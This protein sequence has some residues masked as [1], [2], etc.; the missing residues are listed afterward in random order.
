MD[1]EPVVDG[2]VGL[3]VGLHR[4]V[5]VGVAGPHMG[6]HRREGRP[7]GRVLD[8]LNRCGKAG[9]LGDLEKLANVMLLNGAGRR[10]GGS[11]GARELGRRCSPTRGRG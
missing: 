4:D 11:E 5:V 8:D 2:E 6:L 3:R 10:D 1:L 9:G 7:V